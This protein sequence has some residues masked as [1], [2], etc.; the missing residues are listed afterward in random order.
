MIKEKI[1]QSIR[2]LR[3]QEM[4]DKYERL[5]LP[6]MLV[7][8]LIVD[9]I[10]F[11][12][13]KVSTAFTILCVYLVIAGST[14]AFINIFDSRIRRGRNRLRYLRLASPLIVQFTF[15]A[16]LSASLIFYW[17]SGT[18]SVSWPLIFIIA[19]L[20]VSND[21][22]K[23]RYLSPKVQIGVYYFALFSLSSLIFPFIF[24]SISAWVFV[25]GGVVSALLMY[26][27]ITLLAKSVEDIRNV[28]I[29]L[30]WVIGLIF[31]FLNGLYFLN[32]I[33]PIP[34]SL[35]EAGVYHN[36]KQ[37]SGLYML[38][39]ERESLLDKIIPGQTIHIEKGQSVYAYSAIF[40]PAELNTV[41]V[42]NWEY[43]DSDTRR[44]ISK[45]KLTF[46]IYGGRDEGFRGY[47]AKSQVSAGKWRVS[48]ETERGQVLGRLRFGV[49]IVDVAPDLIKSTR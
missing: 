1:Q 42:H 25:L 22:F 35:R 36:V 21:V 27:Y 4:Y 15:G 30:F 40:A 14:I 37:S 28:K 17:F 2:F 41:I 8:G 46:R 6:A 32:V 44:W 34:L 19:F 38:S 7:V 11:R 5:L 31:I 26:A 47:S 23:D 12:T 48:V 10:T 16:L 33:P 24:N 13:I 20:I 29:K 9:F 39:G 49:E 3:I 43:F 18:V 45:D